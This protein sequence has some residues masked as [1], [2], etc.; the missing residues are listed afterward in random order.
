M[1]CFLN[2]KKGKS[3]CEK[4]NSKHKPYDSFL[5]AAFWARF[6]NEFF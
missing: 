6:L 1:L 3:E 2:K 4:N 5:L